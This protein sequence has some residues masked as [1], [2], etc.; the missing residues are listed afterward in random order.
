MPKND[1]HNLIHFHVGI[2]SEKN[3]K[4]RKTTIKIDPEDI[5]ATGGVLVALV[6]SLAMVSGAAPI[7][8]Y[9]VSVV[10][11]FGCG[12]AVARVV[13]ARRKPNGRYSWV[14]PALIMGLVA[15]FAIYVLATG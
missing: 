11:L 4:K 12:I 13:K 9:T 7:N 8:K 1:D 3:G 5:I 2:S 10:G 14:W 15:V 6:F